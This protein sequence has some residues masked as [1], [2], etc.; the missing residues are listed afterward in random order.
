[1]HTAH[2]LQWIAGLAYEKNILARLEPT[3]EARSQHSADDVA[4]SAGGPMVDVAVAG[5]RFWAA[6][7]T[8]EA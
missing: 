5:S 1:M 2:Y 7:D 8:Q 6:Q 4:R 3:T